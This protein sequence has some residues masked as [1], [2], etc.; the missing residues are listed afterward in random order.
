MRDYKLAPW[1]SK[2][3]YP[4]L[5]HNLNQYLKKKEKTHSLALP[6]QPFDDLFLNKSKLY[7][8]SRELFLKQKGSFEPR[9]VTSA[10]SLSS[11]ILLENRIQYSPTQDEIFWVVNDKNQSESEKLKELQTLVSYS[12]SLFH[13]QNH[14]ILWNQIGAPTDISKDGLRRALNL[15]ESI[16]IG[17]DMALGDELRPEL[18]SLGYLSATLY[19]PGSY[20]K[21]KNKREQY[22]YY[23]LVVRSTFLLLEYYNKKRILKSLPTLAPELPQ[24]LAEHAVER[25]L[26]LDEQFVFFTNPTWQ[27]KNQKRVHDY[28]KKL[29]QKS[30]KHLDIHV[31]PDLWIDP[32]LAFESLLKTYLG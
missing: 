30:K 12:V 10:R 31:G 32:Y 29:K 20:V 17:L 14:R 22:N 25:A 19:D 23:H 4:V 26:R 6:G 13:E 16:I 8:K 11:A 24:E 15:S 7:K 27:E 5:L 1:K 3:H 9:L 2:N 28:F 18:S 21:F